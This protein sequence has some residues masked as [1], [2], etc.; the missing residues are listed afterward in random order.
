MQ[1]KSSYRKAVE[2]VHQILHGDSSAKLSSLLEDWINKYDRMVK[3]LQMTVL[4]HLEQLYNSI[5]E[6]ISE[7]WNNL[8]KS[9]EPTYI[10]ILHYMEQVAFTVST[11][12]LGKGLSKY[13]VGRWSRGEEGRESESGESQLF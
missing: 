12:F 7:A 6:S 1:I 2:L 8:L 9:I 13:V 5:T 4:R 11:E 3:E 10:Q